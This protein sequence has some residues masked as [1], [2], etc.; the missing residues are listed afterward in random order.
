[1]Y[2][3]CQYHPCLNGARCAPSNTGEGYKCI[4]P[5]GFTGDRCEQQGQR[6]YPGNNATDAFFLHFLGGEIIISQLRFIFVLVVN[7]LHILSLCV[8]DEGY[9]RDAWCTHTKF[10]IYVFIIINYS[11]TCIKRSP[12]GQ[13]KNVLIR[14]VTS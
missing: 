3:A 14:Q 6:C 2:D 10:D 4:C 13:R 1:M 5:Q 8:P 11:Q 12:L 7:Q 9:S